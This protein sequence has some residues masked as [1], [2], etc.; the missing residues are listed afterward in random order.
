MSINSQKK[1]TV[2]LKQLL[3]YYNS[4]VRIKQRVCI[5]LK[6]VVF[7]SKPLIVYFSESGTTK[8]FAED[9]K[10]I[11]GGDLFRIEP[12]FKY[13]TEY[14]ELA[15]FARNERDRD[16]RPEI[17][18]KLNNLDDYNNVFLGYPMWWY[19]FP[20][21][22]RTFLDT[23]DLSGKTIIPFNTHEGSGDGGTYKELQDYVPNAKVLVGLPIRGTNMKYDQKG[24]IKEW[25]DSLKIDFKNN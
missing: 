21:I 24:N 25:L 11:T 2:V 5:I 20:Q 12:A 8:K 22:I 7:T 4:F 6:E 23:Y 16:L 14:E 19:T 3:I 9:I 17:K 1:K 10:D 15:D 13:P 18:N